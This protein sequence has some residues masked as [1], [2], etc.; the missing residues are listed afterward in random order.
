M[1]KILSVPLCLLFSILSYSG[2]SQSDSA[3]PVP[4]SFSF[5]PD[6][7]NT[8]SEAQN[9]SVSLRVTDD[10]SGVE[11]AL[12]YWLDPL[13]NNNIHT[14]WTI[15]PASNDTTLTGTTIFPK[16]SPEGDWVIDRIALKDRVNDW[17]HYYT[18]ELKEM[19]ISADLHVISKSDTIPPI[20][21]SFSF[22][23]DTINTI[24][25]DQNVLISLRV[26][27]DLSGVKFAQIYWLDPLG[28][29]NIY[30]AWTL[31]TPSNDETL[32]GTTVFPK[33]SSAGDWVIDRIALKDQVNDWKQYYT[34]ELKEMG[35]SAKIHVISQTDSTP[36]LPVSFFFSPDTINTSNED[37]TV[38]VSLRVTDDLSGVK[39][40]QLYWLDPL[41]NNNIYTAWTL[42][43]PS[44]DK[45]LTGTTLFPEG[46]PFGDW[47]IDRI[48]LKDQ[49]NDWKQ[50]YTEEL[51]EM[52]ISAKLVNDPGS[53]S[54][55]IGVTTLVA[56][57]ISKTSAQLNGF[58][59]LNGGQH[60]LYFGYGKGDIINQE[61]EV[62]VSLDGVY[63]SSFNTFIQ[64]TD[65]APNTK[66]SYRL[67][68]KDFSD[69]AQEYG[70]IL[71]F[72]TLENKSPV[73]K[74]STYYAT[75]NLDVKSNFASLRASD[76]D[77]DMLSYQILSG[78]DDATFA[79]S[80]EGKLILEKA[81]DYETKK[82]YSLSIEASDGYLSDN[83][84][85]NIIV[86]DRNEAPIARD[87]TFM[88]EEN[89]SIPTVIGELNTTDPENN[90]LSYSISSGNDD[91]I[92]SINSEGK[93]LLEKKVDFESKDQHSLMV[94][95]SDGEFNTN[96]TVLIDVVNVNEAPVVSD[97]TYS[98]QEN[99]SIS[100]EIGK[101]DASDPEDDV[102]NY[103]ILSGN[104]D[105]IFSINSEGKLLLEKKV[106]FES[107]DRHSLQV[108]V[109]DGEFNTSVTVLIN[110][111]NVN[112]APVVND[113]TYSIQENA[114]ISAEIGKLDA[115]DP[116]Y[117]D[118]SYSIT[119]GNDDGIFSIN[120]EGKLLLEKK[121]DFESKDQHSLQVDAS[122]GEFNT[123]VTVLINVANVNEAPVVNDA[124][125][126]I[127]ENASISTEIGKLDASDPENDD[128][129]YSITSGNEDGIFSISSEGIVILESSVDYED[130]TSY[131]FTIEIS[132]GE[133]SNTGDITINVGNVND[134]APTNILFDNSDESFVLIG[135]LH[136]VGQLQIQLSS[137]DPDSDT[138]T[139]SLKEGD[140]SD[141]NE[142]FEISGSTLT[143]KV[144]FDDQDKVYRVRIVSSDGEHSIEE[145]F[146]IKV[147]GSSRKFGELFFRHK[148][149][150]IGIEKKECL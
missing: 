96:A 108:D 89:T 97:A 78:N 131:T 118:L 43:P 100:A 127:Q 117:D 15:N 77:G 51:K 106:D 39:Y 7:I 138:F 73:I 67:F 13:G 102:L 140:G 17:K 134:E 80:S 84:S 18:D 8:T 120:S 82:Q 124:T 63:N 65:L 20:P 59:C 90:T 112:E 26:T 36:P 38:S 14:A 95:V 32:S 115:S 133:L 148:Y 104:D 47:V 123:S 25:E 35:M 21:V 110:V 149:L 139:Y 119:S 129:S 71:S 62:G 70:N 40:A 33:N 55:P 22:S 135:E 113:A 16:N 68:S 143:N 50:Y 64:I 37:Q 99:A 28:N 111:A 76:P 69:Q 128:L 137:E 74:D 61:I 94:D 19:G 66:Y 34:D 81:L 130:I 56:S 2:F 93:L 11:S 46:S 98:I 150:I 126:S 3:P 141:N 57:A 142:S 85:I 12:I 1:K 101:L 132:D 103:S 45:T 75:E 54:Y 109:S 122:D 48:A 9:V 145:T 24:N 105:G 41:G 92:F 27:D 114:S 88:V 83:A 4:V 87:S 5:S 121:V 107:K 49:V 30:T 53:T 60:K 10:V 86:D 6:T 31:D 29:N 52:G 116:E 42:D 23:P 136:T 125:Y 146:E 79:I 147:K 44:N 144:I 91:G 58:V 72:T